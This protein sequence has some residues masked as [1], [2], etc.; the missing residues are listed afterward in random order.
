MSIKKIWQTTPIAYKIFL[1]ILLFISAVEIIAAI[2]VWQF[3][4]KVLIEQERQNLTKELNSHKKMLLSYLSFLEKETTFLASLEIMDDIIAKDIDKRVITLLE[5]KSHDLGNGI[6][7][8]VT[9]LNNRITIANK[10]L[11]NSSIHNIKQNNLIFQTK[12][13]TS[14]NP[15]KEIGKLNLLYPFKNLTN[16]NSGNPNKRLWLT[17]PSHIDGFKKA[18]K[19]NT[20]IISQK[21]N[22][23]LKGWKLSISYNKEEALSTLTNI[24]KIQFYT[25]LIATISLGVIIFFLSKY[26]TMP[27]ITLLKNSEKALEAKSTFLSIISHELRTPL[28]SILNLTQHLMVSPKI[29][30]EELKMVTAIETSSGYLLSMINNI[31][32]LSK[33]ESNIITAHKEKIDIKEIIEEIFEI[34]EPL[35]L[36]KETLFEKHI[37][38]ENRY[39]I[40]DSNLFKQVVINL[41][42]NAIKFTNRGKI[43]IKL[44]QNREDYSIEITDTGIGIDPKRQKQLFQPFFQANIDIK[45]LKN[46]SGLG[47][48]L[49][50]K[51]AKLLNGDIKIISKGEGR[52]T[53]AIFN[54]RSL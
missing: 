24:E 29:E 9:D 7:L 23:I 6:S 13:Y 26:L 40:T 1:L 12:I 46:S 8:I 42:S 21:L 2:F 38:I 18:N 36:D 31:L 35:V 22:K 4:S 17:P 34:T 10:R 43:L 39:I 50:Q 28:G 51:V 16:L 33:L 44:S 47:L 27:L 53:T 41:L 30:D 49:S 15:K 52:G 19:N 14:F 5:R 37:T 20:I 3:E 11:L 45:H 25:F 48:A 54:F 32:Q